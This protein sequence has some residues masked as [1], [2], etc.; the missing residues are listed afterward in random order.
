MSEE[1]V[2]ALVAEKTAGIKVI[3]KNEYDTYV[4]P[5]IKEL[6]LVATR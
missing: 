5:V 6:I 1:E 3:I 2:R 4:M